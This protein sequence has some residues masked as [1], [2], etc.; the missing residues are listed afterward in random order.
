MA[1]YKSLA[2]SISLGVSTA[3]RLCSSES[4]SALSGLLDTMKSAM[5]A[6]SG[7]IRIT[8]FTVYGLRLGVIYEILLMNTQGRVLF[9]Y[10]PADSDFF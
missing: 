2:S 3:V 6:W 4:T 5:L 10:V 9:I 8:L 1:P 7:K